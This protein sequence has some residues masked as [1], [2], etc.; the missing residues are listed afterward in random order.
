MLGEVSVRSK[1]V[2]VR[3]GEICMRWQSKRSLRP[4]DIS[5]GRED[6]VSSR[7]FSVR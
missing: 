6:S 5:K 2:S 7:R 4:G 1:E 3:S